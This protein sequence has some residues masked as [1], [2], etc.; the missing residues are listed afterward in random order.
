[1][2]R[3]G[4]VR[5]EAAFGLPLCVVALRVVAAALACTLPANGVAAQDLT[6]AVAGP[7][8]GHAQRLGLELKTGA[9][10]AVEDING[11]GGVLGRKLTLALHDDKCEP[12]PAAAIATELAAAAPAL[13]IGHA[14]TTSALAAADI[15]GRTNT[16]FI[17]TGSAH[18]RLTSPR[19]GPTVFRLPAKETIIGD[20]IA[21]EL[22]TFFPSGAIAIVHDRAQVSRVAAQQVITALTRFNRAPGVVIPFASGEK[23]YDTLIDAVLAAEPAGLLF[24]GFPQEAAMIVK[25]LRARGSNATVFGTDT[26][27]VADFWKL[28]DAAGQGVIVPLAPDLTAWPEAKPLAARLAAR[29]VNPTRAAILAYSAIVA[30][31]AAAESAQSVAH[32]DVSTALGKTRFATPIGVFGFGADGEPTIPAYTLNVWRNGE[33]VPVRPPGSTP[34]AAPAAKAP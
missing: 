6:I 27:A 12:L 4:Q 16:L 31:T 20:F 5:R 32:G 23:S 7:M 14:C 34:P 10:L 8:T 18:P 26:L 15:Y 9:E 2:V 17:A 13:I 29:G 22:A 11:R 21:V 30:W 1:M 28:A 19:R 3:Y 33:L 24:A 25:G